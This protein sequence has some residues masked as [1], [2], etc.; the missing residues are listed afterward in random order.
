MK[1][2]IASLMIVLVGGSFLVGRL[3][4]EVGVSAPNVSTDSLEQPL[5]STPPRPSDAS[6]AV[7]QRAFDELESA[8]TL[9][10]SE[11][12]ATKA[13]LLEAENAAGRYNAM[14]KRLLQDASFSIRFSTTRLSV[15]NTLFEFLNLDEATERQLGAVFDQTFAEIREWERTAAVVQEHTD[16]RVVYKVPASELEF[17]KKLERSLGG[18]LAEDDRDL[19]MAAFSGYDKKLGSAREISLEL[20]KHDN[21]D[22]LKYQIKAYEINDQGHRAGGYSSTSVYPRDSTIEIDRWSH[23]FEVE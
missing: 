12:A 4:S 1:I 23:L 6:S 19:V 21:P 13:K 7:D 8:Y 3:T 20:L 15:P 18:L 17:S 2:L 16:D 11:L 9:L 10:E 14:R 22:L 5:I